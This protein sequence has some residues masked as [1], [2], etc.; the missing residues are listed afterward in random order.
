MSD[1]Q[2]LTEEQR[3]LLDLP[4]PAE[5]VGKHP[6]KSFLSTIK[7]PYVTERL[8][9]VFGVGRWT[10]KTDLVERVEKMVVVKVIFNVPDYGI[11]YECF[12]GNDNA[13]LGDA[14]KGATTDAMTKIGSWLGIGADVF[15]GKVTPATKTASRPAAK[16]AQ[17]ASPKERKTLGDI[18]CQSPELQRQ[19]FAWAMKKYIAAEDKLSFN[20]IV[21]LKEHY[22]ISSPENELRLLKAWAEYC[23]TAKA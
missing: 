22:N 17:S 23:Q 7:I 1:F 8:N 15:K 2:K 20:I 3:Q 21:T 16:P 11:T 18:E 9:D 19:L 4:L 13:D 14:Y 6:T 10:I 12:G 5:A